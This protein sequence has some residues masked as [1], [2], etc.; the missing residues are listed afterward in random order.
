MA[1]RQPSR[2]DPKGGKNGPK[3]KRTKRN[4]IRR[5]PKT[6]TKATAG[7]LGWR[8]QRLRKEHGLTQGELA[9]RL[10]VKQGAVSA[11]ELGKVK[12]EDFPASALKL[13]CLELGTTEAYLRTGKAGPSLA[14]EDRSPRVKLPPPERGIE[15]LGLGLRGL[16]TEA[17]TLAQ[18]QKALREA[19]RAGRA[20]WLV[21]E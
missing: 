7:T 19:V 11:W 16:S 10:G 17:L 20:V 14:S 3:P 2:P 4:I 1:S 5:G 6:A 12:P 21:M 15:V 8:I 18:A 9:Q 13:I